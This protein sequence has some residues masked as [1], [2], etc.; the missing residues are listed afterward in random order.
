MGMRITIVVVMIVPLV[1]MA[2]RIAVVE[3]TLNPKPYTPSQDF[4][5]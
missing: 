4:K 3:Q 1:A 5:V 2:V